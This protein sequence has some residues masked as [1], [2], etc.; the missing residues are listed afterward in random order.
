MDR[1]S[2]FLFQSECLK[3]NVIWDWQVT[4]NKTPGI[5]FQE[6]NSGKKVRLPRSEYQSLSML[7]VTSEELQLTE[8]LGKLNILI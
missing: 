8:S 2:K 1:E 4:L 3:A 5:F 7:S 6:I